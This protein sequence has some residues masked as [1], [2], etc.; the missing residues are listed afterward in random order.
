MANGPI[1]DSLQVLHKCDTPLCVNPNHLFLGTQQENLDD[2]RRKGRLR[3]GAH[4]IRLSDADLARI[5]TIY[6][7][8]V[9]GK[10]LARE[11]NV[12]LVTILRAVA[13][14]QRVQHRYQP[15]PL[16][17]PVPLEASKVRGDVG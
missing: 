1:T 7:P 16:E 5:R 12:S 13:G 6:R 9:N 15:P 10:Q 14:K 4:L 3:D 2:A 17:A 8:R 11:Y